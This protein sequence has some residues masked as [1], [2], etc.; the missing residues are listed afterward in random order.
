M[1]RHILWSRYKDVSEESAVSF[2]AI[3]PEDSCHFE[4]SFLI[5]AYMP[6]CLKIAMFVVRTVTAVYR[7]KFIARVSNNMYFY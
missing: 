5:D 3:Y 7:D 2:T 1:W 4:I 6:T